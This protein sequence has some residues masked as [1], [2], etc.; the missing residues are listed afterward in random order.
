M[1]K[2]SPLS[3]WPGPTQAPKSNSCASRP[4]GHSASLP[5]RRRTKAGA[6]A[7]SFTMPRCWRPP[8][9]AAMSWHSI[10]RSQQWRSSIC[11]TR[12]GIPKLARAI[13]AR[14]Q[15]SSVSSCQRQL[16][17][18]V[19]HAVPSNPSPHPTFASRLRRL[20]SAG[21]LKRQATQSSRSARPSRLRVEHD[22]A[23]LLRTSAALGNARCPSQGLFMGAHL[24]DRETSNHCLRL[25]YRAQ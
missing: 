1:A 16:L 3:R 22:F 4:R 18:A 7:S 25:R 20:S 6:S 15:T 9:W 21:E 19:M 8:S 24:N 17:R 23:D 10:L 5:S 13:G 12:G 14:T 2:S 11:T